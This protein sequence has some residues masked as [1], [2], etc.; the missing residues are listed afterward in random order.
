MVWRSKSNKKEKKKEKPL[1]Q[2]YGATLPT[3][4]RK[5]SKKKCSGKKKDVVHGEADRPIAIYIL[6]VIQKI[7]KK[8]NVYKKYI[9]KQTSL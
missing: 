5:K 3:E 8:A 7:Q 1:P 6:S 4:N 2:D 9:I